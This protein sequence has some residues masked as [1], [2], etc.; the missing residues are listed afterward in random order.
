LPVYERYVEEFNLY[1]QHQEIDKKIVF[2]ANEKAAT[3]QQDLEQLDATINEMVQEFSGLVENS[4]LPKLDS[5]F[6]KL[7]KEVKKQ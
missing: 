3:L 6:E 4:V 5:F 1:T 7:E 2:K